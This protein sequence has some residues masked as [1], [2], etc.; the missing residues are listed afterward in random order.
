M[1]SL[2]TYFHPPRS[3][4]DKGGR[5]EEEEDVDNIEAYHS[6]MIIQQ[7]QEQEQLLFECG[8]LRQQLADA[9]LEHQNWKNNL[10]KYVYD[11]FIGKM[12]RAEH[13]QS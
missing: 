3:S 12:Q 4:T 6:K 10:Q 2:P 1:S 5:G 9:Q 11:I 13:Q 8:H 7:Q